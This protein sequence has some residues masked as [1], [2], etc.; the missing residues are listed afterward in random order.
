[1]YRLVFDRGGIS[2]E[3]SININYNNSK[4]FQRLFTQQSKIQGIIYLW[5]LD[6]LDKPEL[7]IADIENYQL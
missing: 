1:M 3:N 6:N 4:D 5:S 2:T 7:T